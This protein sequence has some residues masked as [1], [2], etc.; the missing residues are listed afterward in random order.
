[1]RGGGGSERGGGGGSSHATGCR[2]SHLP[3]NGKNVFSHNGVVCIRPDQYDQAASVHL[4]R[5]GPEVR[6]AEAD[7]PVN[8]VHLA[9]R[10][11][12]DTVIMRC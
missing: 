5:H 8:A 7:D 6:L 9:A 4:R 12:G 2:Y 3:E 1:M 10:R 11:D